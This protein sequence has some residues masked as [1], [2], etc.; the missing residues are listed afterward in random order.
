LDTISKLKYDGLLPEY[1]DG[2][3][4]NT[5]LRQFQSW[6]GTGYLPQQMHTAI[7]WSKSSPFTVL[8]SKETEWH[9]P[10]STGS[11]HKVSKLKDNTS[12]VMAKGSIPL[13]Q[14]NDANSHRKH[15]LDDETKCKKLKTDYI[16]SLNLKKHK[17]LDDEHTFVKK[18]KLARL[19]FDEEH[20]TDPQGLIWDGVNYSCAY[21]AFFSI[22][23]NIWLEDPTK[24]T[25]QFGDISQRMAVLAQGL[26]NVNQGIM[27]VENLRNNIHHT[28]N[29]EYPD[30]FP[31]GHQ[32]ASVEQL[33]EKMVYMQGTHAFA[34]LQCTGC[35]FMDDP[36]ID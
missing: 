27:T 34:Q 20:S 2:H 16:Q 24:W 8:E 13:Y 12:Y 25:N 19:P 31:N 1:I 10:K 22:L 11:S 30:I 4:C 33:A 5:L 23:W 17:L 35:D 9:M 3:R 29:Q 6:K 14:S 15:K 7:Q 26:K 32:G 36:L 18:N 21:D 28:L